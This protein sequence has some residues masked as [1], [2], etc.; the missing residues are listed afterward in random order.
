MKMILSVSWRQLPECQKMEVHTF[1]C[2]LPHVVQTLR[3]IIS[4][5][6]FTNSIVY[7]KYFLAFQSTNN[8]FIVHLYNVMFMLRAH[9]A[10]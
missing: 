10:S 9:S 2:L 7:T 3:F 5:N 6:S 8:V 4:T 1:S